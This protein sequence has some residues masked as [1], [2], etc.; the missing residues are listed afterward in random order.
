MANSCNVCKLSDDIQDLIYDLL[1]RQGVKAHSAYIKVCKALKEQGLNPPN[2]SSF[3]THVKSHL[4]PER[5]ALMTIARGEDQMSES[6]RGFD[7][8]LF[9]YLLKKW[10]E[11]KGNRQSLQNLIKKIDK[12]VDT[13]KLDANDLAKL[14]GALSYAVKT[15]QE[16]NLIVLV[17]SKVI[18]E[19]LA[20]I[21]YSVEKEVAIKLRQTRDTL[22]LKVKPGDE[23][24]RLIDE[25][26]S[27]IV[28]SCEDIYQMSIH[29]L[30][31]L[32]DYKQ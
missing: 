19:L 30:E 9:A 26:L 28:K 11:E 24:K 16:G 23:A 15:L 22:L 25:A 10:E 27:S 3:Y 20:G 12:Q 7:N 1:I 6:A 31:N 18:N 29:Q 4:D 17:Q 2:R 32:K 13:G 21:I 8:I 5:S 14:G